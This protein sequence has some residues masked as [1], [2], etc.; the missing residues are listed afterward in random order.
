MDN[1]VKIKCRKCLLEDMDENDFLRDMRS[2]IA[3]YPADKKVSEEEYRQR[4]A[5]CKDCEKLVDGMC[6]L[7]G[8]YVELRASTA[9][10]SSAACS[11]SALITLSGLTLWAPLSL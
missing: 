11:P 10:R 1:A 7:C 9:T 3:A 4:L 6:V 8:C 2:H 5:F